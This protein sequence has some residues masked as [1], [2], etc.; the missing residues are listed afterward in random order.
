MSIGINISISA[1]R[2]GGLSTEALAWQTNIIANGGTIP[3]ATLAIFD[4][5]FFKPAKANGSI[6]SELDRLNLYCG[7]VGYEIAARTNVIKSAHYVTPVSSPTF[8]NNGYKSSGT[9]YL[10]LNYIQSTQAV[11]LTQNSAK[12][13]CV[14]KTPPFSALIRMMGAIGSTSRATYI[15][16]TSTPASFTVINSLDGAVTNTNVVTSGNVFI[17][18]AR[19]N[20]TQVDPIINGVSLAGAQ[21]S[22]ATAINVS[23][24]ELTL[25]N[26]GAPLSGYD[27]NY[28]LCSWHGSG[29][30]DNAAL[31]T[32]LTNLFSTLGV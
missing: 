9:S 3:A 10:D 29:A 4:N 26:N 16:R 28:H 12:I 5:Y 11:K 27:T 2:Y 31:R 14:V 7:L 32:I 19:V 15:G 20:S 8:D 24:F 17:E 30:L 13:G 22:N 6:L 23:A 18:G 1:Q 25:N 21:N